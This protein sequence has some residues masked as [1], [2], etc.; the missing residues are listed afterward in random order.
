M[1]LAALAAS[2][3]DDIDTGAAFSVSLVGVLVWAPLAWGGNITTQR[4]QRHARNQPN[5]KQVVGHWGKTSKLR[6]QS[7]AHLPSIAYAPLVQLR[8]QAR[9][10]TPLI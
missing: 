7:Q 10:Q 8:I 9:A 4:V 5:T 1:S 2:E 3:S 6:L